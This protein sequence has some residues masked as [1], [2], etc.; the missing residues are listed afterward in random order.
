MKAAIC[1]GCGAPVQ[2]R[3]SDAV[4][5]VCEYCQSVLVR[6][7]IDLERVGKAATIP[8]DAS[9]IQLGTEGIYRNKAFHVVG[10]IVYAYEQ[11]SWNEWHLLFQ[12]GI[13]GWLSDAQLEYAVSFVASEKEIPPEDAIK[14]GDQFTWKNN[15]YQV[16]SITRAHYVSVAGDLPFVYWDKSNVIF[17]DLRTISGGFATIDYTETPPLLFLGDAVDFDTLK[18]KNL[19]DFEGGHRWPLPSL[20]F[21]R[22][23][24][25]I[26]AALSNARVRAERECHMYSVPVGAGCA[27]A[28]VAGFAAVSVH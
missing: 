13:S 20:K 19:R 26:A 25:P 16:T 1:P 10:R 15:G 11:G 5:T 9:P 7:D 3:W 18:L 17:A 28:R 12:D 22:S 2:F 4:Q 8:E 24:A 14:R 27:D 23:P 6:H 21:K